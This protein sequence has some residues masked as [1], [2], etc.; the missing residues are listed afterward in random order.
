MNSHWLVTLV[1][2]V[3]PPVTKISPDFSLIAAKLTRATFKG[4]F[5]IIYHCL[6]FKA[7]SVT[8]L[9]TSKVRVEYG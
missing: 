5:T 3:L 4:Y 2:D 8:S 1:F 6:F 7:I 9:E